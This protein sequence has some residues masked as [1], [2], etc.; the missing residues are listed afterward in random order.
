VVAL[1]T[2]PG[3]I[4]EPAIAKGSGSTECPLPPASR[5]SAGAKSG[6]TAVIV[7]AL[8]SGDPDRLWNRFLTEA[9]EVVDAALE[10][11]NPV[12]A[13]LLDLEAEDTPAYRPGRPLPVGEV[14]DQGFILTIDVRDT[15][16]GQVLDWI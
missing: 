9:Q 10:E 3:G 15:G 14:G 8:G 6:E 4:A 1:T 16:Q 7:A 5:T 11:P 2:E 12:L 13:D